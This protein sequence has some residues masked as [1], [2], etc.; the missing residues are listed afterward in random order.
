ME[1]QDG[2]LP[3]SLIKY[4]KRLSKSLPLANYTDERLDKE[5]RKKNIINDR[6]VFW[7][8]VYQNQLYIIR[9]DSLK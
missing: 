9:K 1:K 4:G 8:Y 2:S 3:I 5:L 7:A 6:D